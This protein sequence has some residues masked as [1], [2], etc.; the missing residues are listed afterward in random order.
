ML[1]DLL[2]VDLRQFSPRNVPATAALVEQQR[3]SADDITQWLTDAVVNGALLPGTHGGGF[4][5]T[6]AS[7]VLH[8]AYA[9]WAATQGIRRVK[10]SREFGRA[11]GELGLAR[12]AGNNP[13]KWTIPDRA[14]LHAAAD[15]RAGIR[16]VTR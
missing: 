3:R 15:R 5:T 6:V 11:L 13:P 7:N 10:T 4:N 2:A 8:G 14:A 1:H 16:R 12:G 9:A